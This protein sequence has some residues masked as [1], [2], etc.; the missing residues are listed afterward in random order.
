MIFFI[1]AKVQMNALNV[2]HERKKVGMERFSRFESQIHEPFLRQL[3]P[4]S[5]TWKNFNKQKL[6]KLR[7]THVELDIY[8]N[9]DK[10]D[11]NK[12]QG[13]WGNPFA[14]TKGC[15]KIGGWCSGANRCCGKLKCKMSRCHT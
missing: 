15:V 9:G 8:I 12:G 11:V 6:F 14:K 10:I 5:H 7:D 2:L 4:V 13:I 3:E 1:R